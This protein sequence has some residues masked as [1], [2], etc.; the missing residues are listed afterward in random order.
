MN[1]RSM[2]HTFVVAAKGTAGSYLTGRVTTPEAFNFWR[3][4]GSIHIAMQMV[5]RINLNHDITDSEKVFNV[6]AESN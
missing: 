2:L 1:Y 4:I 6:C 5:I 3:A